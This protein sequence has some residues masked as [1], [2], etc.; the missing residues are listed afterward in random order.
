MHH[1]HCR[2]YDN[3]FP[4]GELIRYGVAELWKAK[5]A[6][7]GRTKPTRAPKPADKQCKKNDGRP[8]NTV[9]E[10]MG[11]PATK[12][13]AKASKGVT[14]TPKKV[15]KPTENPPTMPKLGP[16]SYRW[17]A[18]SCWLDASLQVLY[19]AV[20]KQFDEFKTVFQHLKSDCGLKPFYEAINGWV[21]LDL[22]LKDASAILMSQRDQ[23]RIFLHRKKIITS[24]DHP[25]SAVVS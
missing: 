3:Q 1:L 6:A 17:N 24:L 4:G 16:A 21:E 23:L 13:P 14:F 15:A 11:K 2:S 10:L 20:T 5:A 12:P 18:N 9:K 22:E 25:E 19:M 8:P 7:I